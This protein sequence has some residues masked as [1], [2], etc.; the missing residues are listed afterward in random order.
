MTRC[1]KE[2]KEQVY[3]RNT[4]VRSIGLATTTTHYRSEQE[5]A[6]VY[7]C[8]LEY[9]YIYLKL[10]WVAKCWALAC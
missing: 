10:R 1:W 8:F 7:T 4:M 5:R 9:L 6:Y 3:P 2:N